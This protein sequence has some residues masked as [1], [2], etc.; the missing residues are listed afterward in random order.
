MAGEGSRCGHRPSPL[1]RRHDCPACRQSSAVARRSTRRCSLVD[2]NQTACVLRLQL[3]P[4]CC[5]GERPSCTTAGR[6]RRER[7]RTAAAGRSLSGSASARLRLPRRAAASESYPS[8]PSP[9]RWT[10]CSRIG[11]QNRRTLP[12]NQQRHMFHENKFTCYLLILILVQVNI[13]VFTWTRI[14]KYV[15][16]SS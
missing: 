9:S 4:H 8:R 14:L 13:S 2:G 11:P 6:R 7:C 10:P 12:P 16:S 5:V 1:W 3:R 15:Y